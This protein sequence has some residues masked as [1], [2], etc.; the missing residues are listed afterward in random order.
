[1]PYLPGGDCI[2]CLDFREHAP[3]S[4]SRNKLS[5]LLALNSKD[6]A[7][8]AC[9]SSASAWN[10]LGQNEGDSDAVASWNLGLM[11]GRSSLRGMA[12][13]S[14]NLTAFQLLKYAAQLDVANVAACKRLES[15]STQSVS[16]KD[17]LESQT[18]SKHNPQVFQPSWPMHSSPKPLMPLMFTA[19]TS[20]LFSKATGLVGAQMQH[21]ERQHY[22]P[23][24]PVSQR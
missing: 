8:T 5:I 20:K 19:S 14:S 16:N 24:R 1:M 23:S 12:P 6:D 13:L 7:E 18:C 4:H 3:Q 10:T 22:F 15:C 2:V 11:D 17:L 21:K 9:C